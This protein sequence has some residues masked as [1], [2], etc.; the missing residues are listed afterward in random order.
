MTDLSIIIPIYNTPVRELQ[1]C[2]DSIAAPR[3]AVWEVLCVDDGSEAAVGTF[4][5][6]YAQAHPMFRYLRKENGGVSSA[7]NLGIAQAAGKYL[8]FLDA[9]D[10][11]LSQALAQALTPQQNADLIFFDI[12]LTQLGKDSLWQ[13]FS[14]PQGNL[15]REQVLYALCT[16]ASISG[17]WA[18]LYK[19]EALRT[20]N[21]QFDTDFITGEDW[22]FVCDCAMHTEQ[23][24][25]RKACAYRYF[26]AQATSQGRMLRF[27][28]TMLQNLV[29]R[30]NRKLEVMSR[31]TWTQ[32][33]PAQVHSLASAELIENLFNAAATLRLAKALS[34]ERLTYIRQNAQ[35]CAEH[36]T[37][38]GK[39]TR[40]KLWVLRSCP[41]ALWPLGA[42]RKLY[43]KFKY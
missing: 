22:M 26:R 2:F 13:A 6:E 23:F 38:A 40:A 32:Y 3:Q 4:C 21:I 27:P 25:Y 1:R 8:T 37:H 28:D 24:L 36:L 34:G 16:G 14:V 7:R 12:Q 10:C 15:T 18:K 43:L 20:H 39:K 29:C 11:L 33:D 35:L 41:A 31:T 19:T 9:D 30:Y 17:P 42:M 5:E